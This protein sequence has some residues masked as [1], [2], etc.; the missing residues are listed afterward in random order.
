MA[1]SLI[2]KWDMVQLAT[3]RTLN[4]SFQDRTLISQPIFNNERGMKMSNRNNVNNNNNDGG[5][6]FLG[7]LTIVFI[8]LKLTGFIAWSW[9][10][11]LS[12]F[13][14]TIAIVIVCLSLAWGLAKIGNKQKFR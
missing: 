7:L 2:N 5:I 13:W 3:L 14:I 1:T 10:W 8:V 12:P 9:L 11:V 6:G 4:P